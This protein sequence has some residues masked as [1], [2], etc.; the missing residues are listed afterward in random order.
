[1]FSYRDS[2]FKHDA[3]GSWVIVSV[4]FVLPRPWRPVLAYP[5]LQRHERLSRTA[6]PTARDIFDAVCE[7]R[8]A[9]LPDPAVTGNAGS[10]FKNP[11][12]R[13]GATNCWRAF[14]AW[15]PYAQPD[16]GYKLAAGWLIDQ[17]GWKGRPRAGVRPPGAG[18][19]EPGRGHGGRHHGAGGAIQ[20][21][22]AER[23]GV[24][25]EPEPVRV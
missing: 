6:S 20:E 12:V 17:C 7:I 16:G 25:L 21:A 2:R 5:D 13:R 8:R 1:M 10:F 19:G 15:F 24:A 11:I 4:R 3:P 23:Y 18:A 22:V 9:K 14:P